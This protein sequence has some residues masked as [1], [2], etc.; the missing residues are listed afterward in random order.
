MHALL[1]LPCL[2]AAPNGVSQRL[3]LSLTL[4]LPPPPQDLLDTPVTPNPAYSPLPPPP[5]DVII[6]VS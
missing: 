5:D 6:E 1:S 4:Q 3:D 2:A